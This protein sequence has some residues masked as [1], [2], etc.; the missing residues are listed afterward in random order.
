LEHPMALVGDEAQVKL[1]WPCL[2]IVL[3]LTQDR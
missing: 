3:L 2:E 1:V